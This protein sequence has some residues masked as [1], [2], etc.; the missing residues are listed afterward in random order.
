MTQGFGSDNLLGEDVDEIRMGLALRQ[1]QRAYDA[2]EAPVGAL[3]YQG[4]ELLGQAHNQRETLQ[5]PTAHAE[6]LAI[7]Q[8]AA[9]L[10]SWRLEGCTLYVTLEPCAMCAGAIV[11]A[12]LERLVFGAWDPKAGACGSVLDVTGCE[13]LNHRVAITA[14]VREAACGQILKDFFRARRAAASAAKSSHGATASPCDEE[15][16]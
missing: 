7:T 5:D 9:A 14:G 3:I 13:K 2:G 16:A 1:A 8:A 15:P 4:D 10:E 12:R 11:L 6:I